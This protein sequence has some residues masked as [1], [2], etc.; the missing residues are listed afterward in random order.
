MKWFKCIAASLCMLSFAVAC[1]KNPTT[2]PPINGGGDD[3]IVEGTLVLTADA[4]EILA[5]GS[6]AVTFTAKYKGFPVDATIKE[7]SSGTTVQNGVFSSSQIGDV[8][9]KAY[10]NNNE[11]N[12]LTIKV[13]EVPDLVLEVDKKTI[14]NTGDDVCTFT[15]YY[16]GENV[17]NQ[18]TLRCMT[19]LETLNGNTWSSTT[20]GRF[21]FR[22]TYD[23]PD[24]TTI[25]SNLPFVNV[26]FPDINNP[27]EL[28]VDSPR[29][30]ANGS[31]V[32]T[33]TV[34]YEG[35]DVTSAA[36][37]RNT[38]TGEY[39]DGNTFSY[40]GNEKFI[41]FVAEYE[42]K[43]SLST[44]VGFGA[45]HK[46][47]LMF[48][49]SGTWCAP[50]TGL[51]QTLEI[52]EEEYG[53]YFTKMCVHMDDEYSVPVGKTYERAFPANTVPIMYLDFDN[54]PHASVST[55]EII[56]KIQNSSQKNPAKV[57]IAATSY[58]DGDNI[59]VTVRLTASETGEYT[60][61]VVLLEDNIFGP[62]VGTDGVNH[63]AVLRAMASSSVNG[64]PIGT[65][66]EN[67]EVI[68]EYTLSRDSAIGDDLR[69]MFYVNAKQGTS[70][71]TTNSASCPVYGRL[72]Y[73]FAE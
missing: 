27:L 6:D 16:K 10:Y 41:P 63:T 36:K 24:G 66:V 64:D 32:A 47:V 71:W 56:T 38:I 25:I 17:T 14:Q 70:Y 3:N 4:S 50:C 69:V 12:E 5:N 52:V 65:L 58:V 62:Q 11:S 34:L 22:A 46:K 33:F 19:T 68:R 40:S 29:I 18:A 23:E 2:E 72:D 73:Q 37:I 8:T 49:F 67:K 44:N 54:T 53:D 15:I 48:E 61:G 55:S 45:F 20:T 30:L 59:K 13:V 1:E 9:F 35:N 42:G 21:Q 60:L 28:Y 43:T 26:V 57:G 51:L 31:D 7:V 39:L